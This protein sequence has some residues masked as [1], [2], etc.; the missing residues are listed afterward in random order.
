[1]YKSF[2]NIDAYQTCFAY[3]PL[4]LV[5][6]GRFEHYGWLY[7]AYMTWGNIWNRHVSMFF[8]SEQICNKYKN[9]CIL[10]WFMDLLST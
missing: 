3:Q 4:D 8:F 6:L 2:E 10:G 5:E 1:M 9:T 7:E